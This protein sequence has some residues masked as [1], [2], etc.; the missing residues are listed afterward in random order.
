LSHRKCA[1]IVVRSHGASHSAARNLIDGAQ[2]QGDDGQRDNDLNQAVYNMK[3]KEM[4][5]GKPMTLDSMPASV[6]IFPRTLA[7]Y[8]IR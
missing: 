4:L 7:R 5:T 8:S 3:G 6:R 1:Q 2:H